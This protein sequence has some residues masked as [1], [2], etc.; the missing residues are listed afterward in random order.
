MEAPVRFFKSFC[1]LSCIACGFT[2]VLA[3]QPDKQAESALPTLGLDVDDQ[4]P[5]PR[6]TENQPPSSG[7]QPLELP[8]ID[9]SKFEQALPDVNSPAA[10]VIRNAIEGKPLEGAVNDPILSDVLNIIRN[11]PD[12]LDLSAFD[13]DQ[14]IRSCSTYADEP[15]PGENATVSTRANAAEQLLKASRLLQQAGR[16]GSRQDDLV[17][18]MRA[19]AVSLLTE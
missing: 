13:P 11:R 4:R 2:W 17:N 5:T 8:E 10:R 16:G 9:L 18:R 3:D 6:K 19:E 15:Q 1:F 14:V 7:L 12:P